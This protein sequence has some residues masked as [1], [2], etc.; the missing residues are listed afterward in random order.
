[1]QP[2]QQS[3]QP[4]QQGSQMV[5]PGQPQSHPAILQQHEQQLQ[6]QQQ[7][8]QSIPG[9][10]QQQQQWQ[11][12]QQ[13]Q[14]QGMMQQP[15]L[16]GQVP[17]RPMTPHMQ[18]QQQIIQQHIQGISMEQ[19]QQFSQMTPPQK[20]Q[21][22][23]E[24]NLLLP[25]PRAGWGPG[26]QQ[27]Q[28]QRHTIQLHLTEQQKQML[29]SMDP[30]QRAVYLQK[31]QKDQMQ[32]QQQHQLMQR[33]QM[34]QQ[35]QQQGGQGIPAQ[36]PGM[37]S[38]AQAGLQPG[39]QQPAL[40]QQGMVSQAGMAQQPVSQASGPGAQWTSGASGGQF[41]AHSPT[42]GSP[43]HSMGSLSPGHV[44]PNRM[45]S[46]G[47]PGLRGAQ[48]W[49]GDPHPA[50]AQ[51]PRTP[52]QIQH[53]QRLQMQRQQVVEGGAAPVEQVQAAAPQQASM[54]PQQPGI[55]S[56]AGPQ[57]G[58]P[59]QAGI[60][61]K[62]PGLPVQG[63][64]MTAQMQQQR[65]LQQQQQN[66]NNTKAALQN[67]LTTR[68]G[69]GGQPLPPS[70]SVSMAPD[71]TAAN[72]LQMMNQQLQQGG[73]MPSP[74]HS[75]QQQAIIQQQQQQALQQQQ[76]AQQQQM[77]AM[78]QR[79]VPM[80]GPGGIP[81]SP[82]HQHGPGMMPGARFPPRAVMPG[83]RPGG[84]PG[85]PQ[86]RMHQFVGHAIETRLPPDLCLLGCIF[87]MV[88]YQDSDEARHISDWRRVITQYG[89]EIED[90]LG[91]RVTHVLAKDQKSATAQQARI[92]GKRLVTAFWL[93]DTV[94][95]K[96][97]LPPWKAIHFPLPANFEPPCVNMI[98]TLT[99]F[100]DRD[101]DYVKEMIKTAG[102]TYTSY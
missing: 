61:G 53:L 21:Y 9:Q 79:Q 60:A 83:L 42:P 102:A 96:K 73:M 67:M 91:A 64:M 74:Q 81:S 58:I 10:Q 70:A 56:Q 1:M 14:Q 63:G 66:P 6:L 75:P 65:M 72:R 89:G 87:V 29:T 101:R 57:P 3:M 95:R 76:A 69:P 93:N 99:G 44:S 98:L 20:Q 2:G 51:V 38:Q 5:R 25:N 30:E 84:M 4:G 46:P 33:Q 13:P 39:Q 43:L 19:R 32:Q 41:P 50:L 49:S 85:V 86:Q 17:A 34:L 27:V 36:Q 90:A 12:G 59:S 47:A 26:G 48:A 77:L 52:Q 28:L 40:S 80:G 68:M 8:G 97:V 35:Q 82:V 23:A 45:P 37:V 22:L 54:M 62:P 15:R 92:E 55:A 78:R 100:E 31:L 11:P 7:Q 18:R 94:V 16:V 71:G 24:R 88:D